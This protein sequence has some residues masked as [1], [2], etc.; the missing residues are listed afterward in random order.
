MLGDTDVTASVKTW[1]VSRKTS[2]SLS[3]KS[4]EL[5]D[6]AKNFQGSIDIAWSNDGTTDDLGDGDEA[7]FTFEATTTTGDV[8]QQMLTV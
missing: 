1:K 3:D 6:K 8:H 5:S 2:D 7:T 4:W